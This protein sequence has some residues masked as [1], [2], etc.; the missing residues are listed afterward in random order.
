MD[1]RTTTQPLSRPIRGSLNFNGEGQTLSNI[2]IW[3]FVEPE[4]LTISTGR[5]ELCNIQ[6]CY[7]S[8]TR[9]EYHTSDLAPD[10][11]VCEYHE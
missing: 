11:L 3:S 4:R 10:R 9:R 8:I 1:A 7:Y 5:P 6:D 2:V